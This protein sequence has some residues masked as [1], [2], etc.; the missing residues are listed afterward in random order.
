MIYSR[1]GAVLPLTGNTTLNSSNANGAG[2]GVSLETETVASGRFSVGFAGALGYQFGLSDKL[3]IFGEL[4]YISLAVKRA[5]VEVTKYVVN[6]ADVLSSL[7]DEQKN[8]T[9]EDE[10]EIG[11]SV[12]QGTSSNYSTVGINI[13]V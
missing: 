10:T 6:G 4:E 13:G 5:S 11:E 9:F 2:P 7:S 3:S 1:I 12:L 8:V